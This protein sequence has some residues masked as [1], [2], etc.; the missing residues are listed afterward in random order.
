[1]PPPEQVVRWLVTEQKT[2]PSLFRFDV[3]RA[4]KVRNIPER[5]EYHLGDEEREDRIE[6]TTTA[7]PVHKGDGGTLTIT[8]EDD[9]DH[10]P[11]AI[12]ATDQ[13]IDLGTFSSLSVEAAALPR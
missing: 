9:A 6:V 11:S 4:G 3:R 5:V 10:R 1:M 2:T 13:Q 12:D 8:V 7:T